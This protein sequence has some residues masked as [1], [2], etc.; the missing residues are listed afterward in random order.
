[1]WLI[2]EDQYRGVK[3]QEGEQ[4]Y[5]RELDLG[6]EEGIPVRTIT[7]GAVLTNIRCPSHDYVKTIALGLRETWHLTDQGISDYLLRTEGVSGNV[8]RAELLHLLSS[9]G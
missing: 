3:L 9:L 5:P 8:E 2:R 7:H 1:M 6:E 4:W